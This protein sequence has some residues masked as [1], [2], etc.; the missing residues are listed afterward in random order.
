MTN[1][2]NRENNNDQSS[3]SGQIMNNKNIKSNKKI[4][5]N[6]IYNEHEINILMYKEAIKIDRRTY[7]E[8]YI[9]L[10]KRKQI[11]IFTFFIKNDYNSRCIKISLF[12]F[13]FSLFFTVNALFFDDDTMHKIY[14]DKGKYDFI[15]RIPFI[16]YSTLISS[17]INSFVKFLSLSENNIIEIKNNIGDYILIKKYIKIKIILFYVLN[18]LLLLFFWYYISCFCAIYKNT[19][20]HL[21]KDTLISFG[22]SLLY[23]IGLCF[24]PG[25]FRLPSLR[26][27]KQDKEC[28][29]KISNFIQNVI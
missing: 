20:M 28:I 26:A 27:S 24:L 11:L 14:I 21:I 7:F 22:L 18:F 16:I 1:R 9:S 10:L 8:Y 15:Y 25:I 23:P 29:Y 5:Q 6:I 13:Y 2:E 4:F 19:Q 17:V 12:L 3:S